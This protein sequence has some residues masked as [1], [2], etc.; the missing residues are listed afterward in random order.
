[1]NNVTLLNYNVHLF[2]PLL[3][4]FAN[5]KGDIIVKDNEI[6]C[7]KIIECLLKVSADIICL[8]EIWY[9]HYARIIIDKTKK[10][11]PYNYQPNIGMN[12]LNG[13]FLGSG[14]LILSKYPLNCKFTKYDNLDGVDKYSQKGFIEAIINLPNKDI[15]LFFTHNQASYY[16]NEYSDII[17]KNLFQL[18]NDIELFKEKYPDKDIIVVGDFNIE[19][20]SNKYKILVKQLAKFGLKDISYLNSE[21]TIDNNNSLVHIFSNNKNKR[22]DYIFA[23]EKFNTN[24]LVLKKENKKDN[25]IAEFVYEKDGIVNDLSDHYP[26]LGRIMF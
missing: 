13:K 20:D 22:V 15:C 9:N 7:E 18:V 24:S 17:L 4:F 23:P 21:Y 2:P 26:L 6:R 8:S 11:Y 14:L 1:M 12:I 10:V 3:Q 5:F 19:D 16:D 25:N